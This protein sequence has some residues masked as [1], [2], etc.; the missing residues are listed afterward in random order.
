MIWSAKAGHIIPEYI[1]SVQWL[2]NVAGDIEIGDLLNLVNEEG[3]N[4]CDSMREVLKSYV[5]HAT[6]ARIES[7]LDLSLSESSTSDHIDQSGKPH[8]QNKLSAFH[9]GKAKNS[10][11]ESEDPGDDQD[12]SDGENGVIYARRSADDD[13]ESKSL[14]GQIAD[15]EQVAQDHDVV[16][17]RDPIVDE[18]ETGTD[19]NRPGIQEVAALAEMGEISHLI[20]DDISRIGR[21]APETLAFIA[22]LKSDHDVTILTPTGPLDI[23]QLEDLIQATMHS[24]VAH[25]STQYRSRSS[26]RSKISNFVDDKD[27]D[28]W[29][30]KVPIGYNLADDGWLEVCSEEVDVVDAMFDRFLKT[31]SYAETARYLNRKYGNKIENNL[32]YY[33]VKQAI[34]NRIYVGEPS[35]TIY[36]DKIDDEDRVVRDSNLQL[37][38]EEKYQ[39]AQEIV[40]E[41]GRTYSDSEESPDTLDPDTAAFRFGLFAATS[42]SP[43]LKILCPTCGE[44]MRCNGQRELDGDWSAHNYQCTDSECATQRK[45]P[46]LDEF[47]DM[48]SR[49][50]QGE[51]QSDSDSESSDE[52][53]NT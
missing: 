15:L 4:Q 53:Q 2:K 35:I 16:L 23:S 30:D 44:P 21:S 11:P 10:G 40:E 37:L 42:T 8:I 19:F 6:C 20:V 46:Y 26:L 36:S 45:W 52:S 50:D 51:E 29:Y 34:Q 33:G 14:E 32:T 39:S 28:S 27:W 48:K 1:T 17:I 47:R 38:G 31:H 22:N 24:L 9:P 13:A 5:T 12:G 3:R 18:G 41:I 43:V 7:Y 25:M 49:S